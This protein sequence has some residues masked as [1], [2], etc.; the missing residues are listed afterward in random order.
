MEIKDGETIKKEIKAHISKRGGT[1]SEWYVGITNDTDR[2]LFQEHNVSEKNDIW[3]RRNAGTLSKAKE[4]E[5]YFTEDLDTKGAPGGT[6]NDSIY[7]YAYKMKSH[8]DP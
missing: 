3:I 4:I 1:Y 6:E 7:V 2:R 5:R 8:T